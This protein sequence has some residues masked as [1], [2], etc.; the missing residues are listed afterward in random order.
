M[1]FSFPLFFSL[2]SCQDSADVTSEALSAPPQE[3]KQIQVAPPEK[4]EVQQQAKPVSAPPPV[5]KKS[6]CNGEAFVVDKDPKG[7][8]VRDKP[9]TKGSTVLG[10]LPTQVSVN[11]KIIRSENGWFQISEASDI[12][13]NSNMPQSGWVSGKLLGI[14]VR[15]YGP[16]SDYFLH[17]DPDTNSAVVIDPGEGNGTLVDCEGQWLKV[18]MGRKV[19][20]LSPEGQCPSDVTN[21]S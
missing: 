8:N 5:D 13:G 4:K 14:G 10:Q 7:L 1:V 19:G 12:D 20:W 3:K 18:K 21:C 17:K 9:T 16:K 11:V 6:G 15:N 2:W